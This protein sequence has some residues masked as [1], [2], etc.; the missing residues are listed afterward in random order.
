MTD[1]S[2]LM[3]RPPLWLRVALPCLFFVLVLVAWQV[4]VRTADISPL[5]L[6]APSAVLDDLRQHAGTLALSTWNT[7]LITLK[8]FVLGTVAGILLAIA[9]SRSRLLEL[10]VSPLLVLT[11]VT[12]TVAIA[13]LV[14]VWVGIDNVDS[15]ILLLAA[16]IA[17]FPVTSNTM[18]GLRSVSHDL[19]DLFTVRRATSL[20]RLFLL[21][22]PAALPYTLAGA[23]MAG[24]MALVGAVVAEF[25]A[26][27]GTDAGLAWRIS[28]AANRLNTPRMFAALFLLGLLGVAISGALSLLQ[29]LCLRRWHESA[30][31]RDR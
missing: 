24:G 19:H 27:S 1:W 14:L 25:V 21:E 12:P 23:R 2:A 29:Y 26:G 15:A 20:Q 10:A 11:Q 22:L 7:L 28:E 3:A 31:S 17:F 16:I 8:A 6:P 4:I 18:L 30:V 13:P 5:I 9:F